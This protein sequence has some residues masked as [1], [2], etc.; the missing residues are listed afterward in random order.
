[1]TITKLFYCPNC[2][3]NLEVEEE[4]FGEIINCPSCNHLLLLGCNSAAFDCLCY[5]CGKEWHYT[6]SDMQYHTYFSPILG[7]YH[8][9]AMIANQI[10]ELSHNII[11][12]CPCCNSINFESSPNQAMIDLY[13]RTIKIDNYRKYKANKSLWKRNI[14][15][16]SWI[17]IVTIFLC[18]LT[19]MTEI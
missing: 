4:M 8:F 14:S 2:N 19:Y 9:G 1:M 7:E 5:E 10:E 3:Q 13:T 6:Q 12:N 18:V 11:S 17:V 15:A 16:C